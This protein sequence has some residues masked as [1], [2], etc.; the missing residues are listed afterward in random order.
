MNPNIHLIPILVF[1]LTN[2]ESQN[3]L[4]KIINIDESKITN[5]KYN[6]PKTN[7]TTSELDV[8]LSKLNE[9]ASKRQIPELSLQD[10]FE[11]DTVRFINRIRLVGNERTSLFYKLG[12]KDTDTPVISTDSPFFAPP[13]STY[14]IGKL[15]GAWVNIYL[16]ADRKDR[17]QRA[18]AVENFV[19]SKSNDPVVAKLIHTNFEH[20]LGVIPEGTVRIKH[21]TIEFDI[22]YKDWIFPYGK[23]L[24]P[25]PSTD[26]FDH[27]LTMSLDIKARDRTVVG[28]PTLLIRTKDDFEQPG[29]YDQSTEL[30]ASVSK[31]I[32]AHAKFD[33]AKNEICPEREVN[34]SQW[35]AVTAVLEKE[36]QGRPVRTAPA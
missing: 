29:I 5:L 26:N 8:V 4:S 11:Q 25:L 27:L 12:L 7:W 19:I 20:R 32:A 9:W 10:L 36:L 1:T 2:D 34:A 35:T 15:V 3:Q 31:F 18:I 14:S 24:A 23:L 17:T 33:R 6:R 30:F 13:D 21:N 16:C 22:N 28:R